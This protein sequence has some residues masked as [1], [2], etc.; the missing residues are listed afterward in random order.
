MLAAAHQ[1]A[2]RRNTGYPETRR[3]E[4]MSKISRLKISN[5]MK[6]ILKKKKTENMKKNNQRRSS[7]SRHRRRHQASRRGDAIAPARCNARR[8]NAARWRQRRA[9]RMASAALAS[10]K[11]R[12]KWR[13]KRRGIGMA[14]AASGGVGGIWRNGR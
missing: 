12:Q 3:G 5:A 10:K 7:S 4:N 13:Y 6:A 11:W 2:F 14:A 1:M 8:N 9:S